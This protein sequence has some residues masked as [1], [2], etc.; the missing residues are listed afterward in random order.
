MKIAVFE[1]IS[2]CFGVER[3]INLINNERKNFPEKKIFCLGHPIHN[4]HISTEL[5]NMN[6]KIIDAN[7]EAFYEVV[8]SLPK[9]S[10]VVFSAHGHD[11]EL[12]KLCLEHDIKYLDTTCPIVKS[13]DSKI[14]TIIDKK[15]K[16][17]YLGKEKHAESYAIIKNNPKVIF[18]DIF[19][20]AV[21]NYLRSAYMK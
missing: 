20:N 9:D 1:P 18:K 7:I 12:E 21:L 11:I 8:P 10:I 19:S 17:V 2:L 5:K 4:E 13:I 3:S 15:Q 14:K 16:V 6:I